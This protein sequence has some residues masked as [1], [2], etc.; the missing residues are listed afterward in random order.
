MPGSEPRPTLGLVLLLAAGAAPA[1]DL[2]RD[3]WLMPAEPEFARPPRE[4]RP[5]LHPL[6]FTRVNLTGNDRP[7]EYARDRE[8]ALI[9]AARS[10]DLAAVERLLHE[11]ANPNRAADEYGERALSHAVALGDVE[12][13]RLLLEAGAD[14]DLRSHG[15]T[16]LGLAA[17]RGQAR[18][19]RMLVAAGSDPDLKGADGN[20]PLYHAALG[21]HAAVIRELL[22]AGPDFTLLNAGLPN[23]EGLTALGVAAMEG[24]L[25]ALEALLKG[26]ADPQTLDKSGRPALFYAVM[27]QRRAAIHLLLAHG[28]QVGAMS[29]DA[30]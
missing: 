10:G 29:V 19:A 4:Q 11:G 22:P 15:L 16:P 27:R 25:A 17:A 21:N 3:A 24:N 23:Y 8:A 26:G 20:T 14:P 30:Y 5:F 2:D 7:P 28:A 1:H 9:T 6:E 18:I 13:V 12:M